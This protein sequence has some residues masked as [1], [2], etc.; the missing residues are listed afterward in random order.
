MQDEK[1]LAYINSGVD[2]MIIQ[3]Q[4]QT[5]INGP[6]I[7][8]TQAYSG[9]TK[10]EYFTLTIYSQNNHLSMIEAMR[11]AKILLAELHA[12]QLNNQPKNEKD[13]INLF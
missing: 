12:F 11:S 7:A 5:G 6:A 3:Q 8:T 4:P 2:A 10:I 1:F 9:L 13:A